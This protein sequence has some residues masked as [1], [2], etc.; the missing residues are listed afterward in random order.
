MSE[1]GK[2]ANESI[3]KGKAAAEQA[4]NSTQQAFTATVENMR[5]YN[6]KMLNMVQANTEAFFEFAHQLTTAKG[7]SEMME[8]WASHARKQFEMLSEQTKELTAL[9]QKMAGKSAE[10]ITRGVNQTFKKAS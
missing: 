1:Y 7:P 8:L 9:G 3:E 6:R 5:D 4:A 2:S 10:P